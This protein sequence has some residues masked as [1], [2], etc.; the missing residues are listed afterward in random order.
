M[1]CPHCGAPLIPGNRF[2]HECR[3]R[4]VAAA[5][6]A[7]PPARRPELAPAPPR[8]TPAPARF[9][10]PGIVTLLGV[11]NIGGGVVAFGVA[12]MMVATLVSSSPEMEVQGV[13]AV[14]LVVYGLIGLLQ[15]ATG[16]G[17]LRLDPWART[18][19]IGLAVVGLLGIP[20]GTIISI[21]ILVYMLKPE[22]KILFSGISPQRLPP[23][24]VARVQQLSQ[25]SGVVVVLIGVIVVIMVV[26][27]V[28]II[29]AI[30]IPSFLRARVSANESA[31]IAT[32]RVVVSAEEAY[33]IANNGFPDQLG[34]LAT[35]SQCIP[36][37]PATSPA[38]L[39][40]SFLAS[41]KSGY[42]FRFVPGPPAPL[43]VLQ[44]GQVSPSSLSGWAYVAVPIRPGQT[45]VRSFCAD[46]SGVLCYRPDGNPPDAAAGA[47]PIS[48][49]IALGTCIPL[50]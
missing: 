38:F 32:L 21:L 42:E 2:C 4:V 46:M 29:A 48:N 45:G 5:P 49:E 14:F 35:P 1:T 12:A 11:L 43:E 15:L 31:A 19:Q 9:T 34:C 16:I 13:A 7:A 26:A 8:T 6:S 10:R 30:A 36:G 22:V 17:L 18:L 20:C 23:D 50:N 3:K 47:C 28:G 44:R 41:Q 25:G 33:S 24:Q 27:F 39:Q 37:R 40:E